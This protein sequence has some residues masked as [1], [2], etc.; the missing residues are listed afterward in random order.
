MSWK[1]NLPESVREWDEVKNSET[2]EDFFNQMAEHRSML[3]QSIRIPGEDAAEEARSQFYSKLTEKVP[4]LVR[5]PDEEDEEGFTAL[6]RR[7]GAPES[8]EEYEGEVAEQLKNTALAAKLT[9]KQFKQ[10]AEAI[11]EEQ[12]A[13]NEAKETKHAEDIKNLKLSWGEAYSEK[14]A[15]AEQVRSQYFPFAPEGEALGAESIKAFVKIGEQ[16]AGES[17]GLTHTSGNTTGALTPAEAKLKISEILRNKEH[18]YWNGRD[19][20]HAAAREKMTAL[21]RAA[22]PG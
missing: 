22:Y 19:P 8:A 2:A 13:A 4:G 20:A 3:G 11:T 1:E 9:K 7:L 10:L 16:M 5:V 17:N 14:L 18:P 6:Y 15:L 21:N 12:K